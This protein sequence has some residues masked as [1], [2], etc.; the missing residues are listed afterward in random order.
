MIEGIST[1]AFFP[2]K[3]IIYF[4]PKGKTCPYCHRSLKVKKTRTK[5]VVTLHI[6]EFTAHETMLYCN[7][8]GRSTVYNSKELKCLAP[9]HCKFGYDVMIYV[10]R[11]VFLRYRTVSEIVSELKSKNIF[12]SNSEI[13]YL[14][15]KFIIYLSIAHQQ[16]SSKIKRTMNIKGGYVLHLDGMCEGDSPTLISALDGISEFVLANIK[17][18]TEKAEQITPL[19]RQLKSR[20]ARP[21]AIVNDMG[22]GIVKAVKEVFPDTPD[23]ICHFH[24]LRDI[25]K[26]L[27][28]NDYSRLRNHLR[29]YGVSAKL[30]QRVRSYKKSLTPEVFE[31]LSASI[32]TKSIVDLEI[33]EFIKASCYSLSLWALEGKHHGN[34]YG[35]PF[36]RP[37][38]CFYQRLHD[39]YLRLKTIKDSYGNAKNK[40]IKPVK[41][42][43]KDLK[44]LVEDRDC[45][46][47]VSNLVEKADVFDRLRDAMRI[48]TS[49]DGKGLNDDG[50]DVDIKTIEQ[51]VKEFRRWLTKNK[52]YPNNKGYHKM[53]AQIDKYWEKL[54]SDPISIE[55]PLG[56]VSIQPQRTN[57][58]M[59]R[60][61]REI[62]RSNRRR[63][64]NNSINKT[65]QAMLSDTPLVKN[66]ENIDYIKILLN[67]KTS[68]EELFSEVDDL[69]VREEMKKISLHEE[70]IPV[71]IRR[72]IKHSNFP[73]NLMHFLKL[74]RAA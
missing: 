69:I 13:T 8:C 16:I 27:M 18:P 34:G 67:G 32:K 7:H 60:F 65:L 22:T 72:M 21:K 40:D 55:T 52:V 2:D 50:E 9:N 23:F 41:Q 57:N 17:I 56:T 63:T 70:K 44:F 4:R 58:L 24:F 68:L 35:F 31:M 11:A 54:F 73:E 1:A 12:L 66:L 29:K 30:R 53:V 25:G 48:T 74:V 64:G 20:Y 71:S 43:L 39:I 36:D 6:G 61:F 14:S 3:P 26:D 62:R 37:H 38:L 51:G 45:K 47:V 15:K 10:G 59:E 5:P 19:L 49:E 28:M 33:S 46:D 42:L